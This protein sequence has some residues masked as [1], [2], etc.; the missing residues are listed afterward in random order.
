[1]NFQD[2]IK[3]YWKNYFNFHGRA[4]RSEY[5]WN[6]FLLF[7][8]QSVL[9]IL[10]DLTTTSWIVAIIYTII[11]VIPTFA[12]KWRRCHDVGISGAA[13]L[14]MFLPFIRI[15]ATIILGLLPTGLNIR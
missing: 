3:S 11:T 10:I 12:L 5:W 9:L 1:M 8:I 6:I 15:G 4:S 7:V 13:N 14:L 2:A